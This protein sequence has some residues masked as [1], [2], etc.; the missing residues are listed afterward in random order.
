MKIT[1]IILLI[2]VASLISGTYSQVASTE[3]DDQFIETTLEPK[4]VILKKTFVGKIKTSIDSS[5]YRKFKT[6]E[7]EIA[8]HSLETK[9]L[10]NI[11]FGDKLN[12]TLTSKK[13]NIPAGNQF[14]G[15]KMIDNANFAL[16]KIDIENGLANNNTTKTY[17][18]SK[19]YIWIGYS[20]GDLSRLQSNKV[21]NYSNSE[22]L[23]SDYISD[24]IEYEGQI[25][26]ATFGGGI[27]IIEDNRISKLNIST[28][29]PSNHITSFCKDAT[30]NLWISTYGEG[31]IRYHKK[32]FH[33]YKTIH[34]STDKIIHKVVED[35][36][37][38]TIWLFDNASNII[39]IDNSYNASI[40]NMVNKP[41]KYNVIDI[42]FGNGLFALLDDK[43]VARFDKK[44]IEVTSIKDAANLTS[45]NSLP[46]NE[47]WIGDEN[48]E[49]YVIYDNSINYIKH[50]NGMGNSSITNIFSDKSNNIWISTLGSGVYRSIKTN[51]TNIHNEKDNFYINNS[52]LCNF[53]DNLV[54]TTNSAVSI[55]NHQNIL[56]HYRHEAIKNILG[57][58]SDGVKLWLANFDG[59]YE[60]S[61]DSL[62]LYK[63][64][65]P[66]QSGYNSNTNVQFQKDILLV[67]NYN[68]GWY[69]RKQGSQKWIKYNDVPITFT[70]AVFIDAQDR[71]WIASSKGGIAY[72]KKDKIYQFDKNVGIVRQYC[73]SAN[74]S[75][76]IATSTGLYEMNDKSVVIKHSFNDQLNSDFKSVTFSKS[77]N[78]IWI[79]SNYNLHFLELSKLS[80]NSY[81]K[82]SGIN[83]VSYTRGAVTSIDSTTYWINNKAIVKFQKQIENE[84]SGNPLIHL[85]D[86]KLNFENVDFEQLRN[87]EILNYDSIVNSIPT[88]L[89]YTK[90]DK[91]INFIF[92]SNQWGEESSLNYYYK[93]GKSEEWIGPI[94]NGQITLN[95]LPLG[96]QTLE[97]K[98]LGVNNVESNIVTYEFTIT[99]P[100]Y[101]E[102]WFISM[103]IGLVILI[104]LI[105]FTIRSNFDFSNFKSFSSYT[106]Y[107]QR[108]RFLA[109]GL[110][111]AFPI[112]EWLTTE[113]LDIATSNW[114]IV[115][116]IA[117]LGL[118]FIMFSYLKTVSET[119][120]SIFSLINSLFIT[121]FIFS[122]ITFEDYNPLFTVELIVIIAF[123]T[124]VFDNIRLFF[125][126]WIVVV[127]TICYSGISVDYQSTDEAI[128]I[129][130]TVLI[131]FFSFAF[132]IFQVNKIGKIVFADKILNTYDKL[133]LVYNKQGEV[134][135]VNP[136][137]NQFF[138]K[139]DNNIL[140]LEWYKLRHCSAEDTLRIKQ[141]IA[142]QIATNNPTTVIDEKIYSS[143]FDT[144]RLINWTF[145]IIE[146]EYLMAIGADVTTLREQEDQISLLSKVTESISNG[147]VIRDA[148][149]KIVWCNESFEKLMEKP[150]ADL[151]G[152]RPSKSFNFPDF[153]KSELEIFEKH[154]GQNLVSIEVPI[155]KDNNEIVW[156]L[157]NETVIY[158]DNGELIQYISI[159]SDITENK[160]KEDEIKNLSLVAE[161]VT[162]GV[163]ITSPEGHVKWCNKSF[164]RITGYSLE[165]ILSQKP[166]DLMKTPDFF[167]EELK[168]F[169][170]N[171][172]VF[173]K[174]RRIAHYNKQGE[175]IWILVNTTPIYDDENNVV[176]IIEIVTDITD[177]K[178]QEE[179]FER[180]SLVAQHS[181]NPIIMMNNRM[182]IDWVNGAFVKEFGYTE[183]EVIGKTP[184]KLLRGKKSDLSK[185]TNLEKIMLKGR[186]GSSEFLLYDKIEQP[187]WIQASVDPVYNRKGKIEQY[188][189]LMQNIQNVKEAQQI[190][191][192]KN[193]DITDSINYA[194]R[195]QSA[196]LPN[197]K[198]IKRNLPEHFMFY[199]PKDVVSGDFYFME[200]TK[201][202]VIVAIADCTGHGV[203]GAMMTSIG[204]AGL[205]NA[206]LDKKLSDPAKILAHLDIYIKNSLSAS[207]EDLTD[208]MDIG[209]M[210]FNYKNRTIEY[211]GAK[212][213]LFL[214]DDKGEMTT[215]PGIKRSIG[216]FTFGEDT[217]FHTTE[218]PIDSPLSI[219]C[220]SDGVPDQFGGEKR[221]KL[222]LKKLNAFLLSNHKLPFKEQHEELENMLNK[223]TNN[224]EI[225]QTDDM[226]LFG[227]KVTLEYF[228][229]LN[230]L[231][232]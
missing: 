73:E 59:L 3:L 178:N 39:N 220:F 171:G 174:P 224:Y 146:G 208:G 165:E 107:L 199:K 202:K 232:D 172:P 98:A 23:T 13:F 56:V 213:P 26:I 42:T 204:A 114:P 226:V 119:S 212:R 92:T 43:R 102:L 221:K 124:I 190:I 83:G 35:P 156:I 7:L 167:M 64:P 153:Y 48:G 215:I 169:T 37:N 18:D 24:I 207:N 228:D 69:E 82:Q 158:D 1:L 128:Y 97:V 225:S 138:E 106:V 180:L 81:N 30:G 113:T 182:E 77:Q 126:Y 79:G 28:N 8:K 166:S 45:I 10:K 2:F 16:S 29:F 211:C 121:L 139:D 155:L 210:A 129:I 179:D 185:F 71:K 200:F 163:V 63:N 162:N 112:I 54:F 230:K 74:G 49:A 160:L 214:V 159:I 34:E 222:Y 41:I 27:S 123:S 101:K 31:L 189:C 108:V 154:Q 15:F 188:I 118:L 120:V 109:F 17:Q 218:I 175:I 191:E 201:N 36:I 193:K 33:H 85:S 206:I 93:I 219:Y 205:N 88:N 51:F 65:L 161:S 144:E 141:N 62:Y 72:V 104:G 22:L 70:T 164:S 105:I 91:S 100:F 96:Q 110:T 4:E 177:Q 130:G 99:Q 137:L 195:I 140:G 203:P 80:L 87:S 181:Q 75:I 148:E 216:E 122:R 67:N 58:S 173:S 40:I 68:Y 134:V 86:I 32:E 152:Q 131:L 12:V 9:F 229:K 231:I 46:S 197:L 95:N 127:M 209:I 66:S 184:G 55:L 192:E 21:T 150:L 187:I 133:V 157:M 168:S 151:I 76:W 20:S 52:T 84:T 6:E 223:W 115:F 90:D 50:N 147:V 78:G 227:A 94:V 61:K 5:I 186:K 117:I 25:W 217:Y 176:Q 143:Q 44:L 89:I 149:D 136:Y 194:K 116:V 125:I 103:L 53:N 60:I 47:I 135:Y 57:I 11:G 111:F 19:G 132:H 196:I 38:N 198:I 183:N 14:E 142:H 170:K 145:Q